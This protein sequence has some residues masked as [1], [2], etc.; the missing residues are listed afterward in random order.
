MPSES[1]IVNRRKNSSGWSL[2]GSPADRH[3]SRLAR[4]RQLEAE[5]I[6]RQQ[7][8]QLAAQEEDV[9]ADVFGGEWQQR[10]AKR[11]LRDFEHKGIDEDLEQLR[12]SWANQFGARPG[13]PA[14]PCPRPFRPSRHLAA[15]VS[16][17]SSRALM[18]L[19]D[20]DDDEPRGPTLAQQGQ[21]AK[22]RL[23]TLE[24]L[25]KVAAGNASPIDITDSIRPSPCASGNHWRQS[26][27]GALQIEDGPKRNTPSVSRN[28]SGSN[29]SRSVFQSKAAAQS[30]TADPWEDWER[31][32][33]HEFQHFDEMRRAQHAAQQAEAEMLA[34]EER[35][36]A[37]A[38]EAEWRRKVEEAKRHSAERASKRKSSQ[39]QGGESSFPSNDPFGAG[40]KF[41]FKSSASQGSSQSGS[42]GTSQGTS[43][44]RSWLPPR[45]PPAPSPPKKISKDPY[46]RSFADFDNA[47]GSF[48]QK[49]SNGSVRVTDVPWP[50]SL[51]TVS[52]I[53]DSDSA[54][55][56]KKKLRAALMRW[57]PDKWGRIIDS[58]SKDEQSLVMERVKEVTQRILDEKN[59]YGG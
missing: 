5:R 58:V 16:S 48:E 41:N 43:Q 1:T 6:Q 46:F 15:P 55:E 17:S 57:H 39:R 34:E 29:M 26:S 45:P 54:A 27:R 23:H 51:P 44:G 21:V 31:R 20:S 52:G 12:G 18:L 25:R 4:G 10:A 32:W 3:V 47:W 14:G 56:K 11:M 8:A 19:D 50:T 13:L 38:A 7:Q 30:A 49:A 53:A 22:S 59:R 40:S 33:A 36:E 28:S 42:Q 37:E 9:E 35:R 24:N 2:D